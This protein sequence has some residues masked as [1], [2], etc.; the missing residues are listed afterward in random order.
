MSTTPAAELARLRV[1]FPDWRIVRSRAGA[2]LA[3]HRVTGARLSGRT[4]A[5]LETQLREWAWGR[6]C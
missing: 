4:V 3:C 1:Q 2:F 5:D 6:M